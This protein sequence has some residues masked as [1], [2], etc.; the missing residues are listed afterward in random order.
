MPPRADWAMHS[1]RKGVTE[2]L[3]TVTRLRDRLASRD[4]SP[5]YTQQHGWA[6]I[7]W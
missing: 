4:R 2:H 7:I 1:G 3:A 6:I 5:C